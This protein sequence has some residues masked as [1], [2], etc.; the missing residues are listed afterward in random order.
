[1]LAVDNGFPSVAKL[2]RRIAFCF[3]SDVRQPFVVLFHFYCRSSDISLR[4]PK[5]FALQ[6][7]QRYL[8]KEGRVRKFFHCF[9]G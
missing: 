5:L 4:K 3:E 1:M 9:Y 7:L 6:I 2:F 8:T